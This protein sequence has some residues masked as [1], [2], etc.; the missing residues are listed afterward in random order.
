MARLSALI[1]RYDRTEALLDGHIGVPG[2]RLEVREENDDGVRQRLGS[3]GA[4]DIWEAYAAR[5]LADRSAGAREF[6][7]IP[8][9]PKRTFRHSATY[10]RRGGDVRE[11]ADLHG[12]RVGVQHWATTAAVWAKGILSDDYGVNLARILWTQVQPDHRAWPRP[13]W[14]DL[15]QAP[16]G[17]D[18]ATMLREGLIDAAITSEPWVPYE[19][20]EF[21]CLLADPAAEERRYFARTR[22]FPIMHVLLVRTS[23]LDADPAL[24]HRLL[25]L[26]T[27]SKNEC[28]ERMTRSRLVVMSMWFH[29]LLDEERAAVGSN[30]TYPWGFRATEHE[31]AKLIEYC[32]KQGI[33]EVPLQPSEVFHPSTLET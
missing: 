18:L 28:I 32:G 6:T 14:L 20:P 23:L 24:G 3:S 15:D 31:I 17:S 5:Y 4:F 19:H 30:D 8:V 7:A 21:A 9:F 1:T 11:P 22:I 25:E 26:W 27:A 10:V 2:L 29:G 16:Q 33:L 13:S 12:C